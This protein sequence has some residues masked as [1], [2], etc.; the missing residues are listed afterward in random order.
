M[1]APVPATGKWLGSVVR[2]HYQYYGVPNNFDSL[3]SFR[4][5]VSRHWK[6]ALSQRSQKG[7][8]T[9]PRMDRLTDKWLVAGVG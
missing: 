3:K 1:H 7:R 8:V 5:D 9:W 6:Q 2:G 4:Y